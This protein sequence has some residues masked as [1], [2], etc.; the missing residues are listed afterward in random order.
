MS[1]WKW[2]QFNY[3]EQVRVWKIIYSPVAAILHAG[4]FS[5]CDRREKERCVIKSI[6]GIHFTTLF[7]LPSRY[8]RLRVIDARYFSRHSRYAYFTLYLFISVYLSDSYCCILTTAIVVLSLA[9]N[10][11][12]HDHSYLLSYKKFMHKR[13]QY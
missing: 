3:K 7:A 5:R 11:R 13:I 2:L 12:Y 10:T 1:N 9:A 6:F 8:I 4:E